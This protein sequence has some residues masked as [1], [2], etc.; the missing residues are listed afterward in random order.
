MPI[1]PKYLE[2]KFW[3]YKEYVH[4]DII[5]MNTLIGKATQWID[6]GISY[7]VVM[8]LDSISIFDL[9]DFYVDAWEKGIKTIY[10]VR[11]IRDN[12]MSSK[13]ECISCAG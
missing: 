7:E 2:E 11:W 13:D 5:K 6:T 9:M 3:Y 1:F 12:Q 8:N 4:H 10:Y